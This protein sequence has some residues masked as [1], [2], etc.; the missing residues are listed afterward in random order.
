MTVIVEESICWDCKA[1]ETCQ[2][3]KR[4]RPGASIRDELESLYSKSKSG[5][6]DTSTY[7]YKVNCEYKR[8]GKELFEILIVNCSMKAQCDDRERLAREAMI[9]P[10][11]QSELRYLYYCTIC[12]KMHISGSGIGME[13]K[14]QMD[15]LKKGD[16]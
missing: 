2:R 7:L 9:N 1:R 15:E 4:L 8:R 6:I 12:K 11:G 10:E 16:K 3:L 14:K 13:H 5:E